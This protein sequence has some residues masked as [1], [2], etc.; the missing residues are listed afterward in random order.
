MLM[1]LGERLPAPLLEPGAMRR[2][3]TELRMRA[4]FGVLWEIKNKNRIVI[5]S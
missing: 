3:E 2:R 4:V 5:P 1:V